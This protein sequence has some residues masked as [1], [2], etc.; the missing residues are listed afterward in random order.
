MVMTDATLEHLLG[1]YYPQFPAQRF[2]GADQHRFANLVR[3]E[4]RTRRSAGV[5]PVRVLDFG[6]GRGATALYDF[7]GP[8]VH[9]HGVDPDAAVF[10]NPY[11]DEASVSDDRMPV[12]DGSVDVVCSSY[13]LEHIERPERTLAEIHR[14]LKPGGR[15]IALTPNA[16]S[17][18]ATVAKLT[19][20]RFHVWLNRRRGCEAR[21]VFPTFYRLNRAGAVR[22]RA[23][24]AGFSEAKLWYWEGRP[25][26]FYFNRM[27]FYAGVAWER[28]VNALPPLSRL[29]SSLFVVLTK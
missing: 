27:T 25:E 14:V 12:A 2:P 9:V 10:E 21:D 1:R 7:R 16:G 8:G 26:Y 6:C 4:I 5:E 28:L 15:F 11:L 23:A 3:D 20:L 18:V 22:G 13:V 17:L 24:E 29:R 19:P